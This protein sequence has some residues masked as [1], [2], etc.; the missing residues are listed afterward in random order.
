MSSATV[1]AA[2]K[3]QWTWEAGADVPVESSPAVVGGV[4]YVGTA[5]GELVALV[6]G[7]RC[8][9]LAATK[10]ASRLVNHRQLSAAAGSTSAISTVRCMR[11]TLPPGS[12]PGPIRTKSE[13]KSSPVVVGDI[14]L[15]GSYDASLYA[16]SAARR[17]RALDGRRPRTTYTARRRSSTASR[18]FA[19][20]DEIFHAVRVTNGQAVFARRRRRP[21]PARRCVSCKG[22][23]YFGTFDNQVVAF[24][25]KARKVRWRYEHPERKFPFYSSAAVID[26]VVM[27]G[28]RDR[29]VHALDA[30]TGKARWTHMTRARIDSSP[31][32]AGGR[33]FVGSNDGR[34]VCA[35]HRVSGKVVVGLRG[36]RCAHVVAC[37]RLGPRRHRVV[38]RPC[39]LRRMT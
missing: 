30:A 20:C 28:G 26:G 13:I 22:V 21:T 2:L 3:R 15:I 24:D 18:H 17:Q 4:V 25:L 1:P 14:V 29:M 36:R 33:V 32:V 6:A 5:D 35:R 34:L 9:A 23:A 8:P 39:R 27:L 10:P 38:R 37:D 12:A 7:R 31:A 11:S 16:L 19:G